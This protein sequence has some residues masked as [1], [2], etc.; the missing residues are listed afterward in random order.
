LPLREEWQ[1]TH[2]AWLPLLALLAVLGLGAAACAGA[3]D[4]EQATDA[5]LTDE[6]TPDGE[7]A[8][9]SRELIVGTTNSL[10]SLDP[11]KAYDY[12]SSNIIQKVAQTL[13]GFAPGETEPSPML[14]ESVDV[15]DDGMEYT[16]TLRSGVSFH[17]GK[18]LTSEDVKF[19]LERVVNMNHPKGAGFLLGGIASIDTPDDLTAVV[20][21]SEPSSMFLARLGY[22]VATIVPSDG[23]YPAPERPLGE[24]VEEGDADEFVSEDLVGTGPYVLGEVRRGES[25]IL[26]ANPD[27]WGEA[28]RNDRVLVR[29]FRTSSQLKLALENGEIDIA[30]RDFSPDEQ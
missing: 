11:A 12:Y 21:L 8:A 2:R 15:S 24:D 28:P 17:N 26:H 22:T 29:F 10:V 27:Y 19:S 18:E 25:I 23:T 1:M 16:F 30:N 4:P 7:T 6:T 14:A 13:V 5:G 3:Q 20:T 9:D